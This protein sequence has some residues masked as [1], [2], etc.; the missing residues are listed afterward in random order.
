METDLC[1][2]FVSKCLTISHLSHGN[3]V[4]VFKYFRETI[5]ISDDRIGLNLAVKHFVEHIFRQADDFVVV[6]LHFLL[7]NKNITS[8][9]IILL[10]KQYI[11][12]E[13][14]F[15]PYNE[16]VSLYFA[17]ESIGTAFQWHSANEIRCRRMIHRHVILNSPET[18]R[19]F[20]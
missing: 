1:L 9:A 6:H 5:F 3:R 10:V 13:Q 4:C 15:R 7:E 2:K 12:N 20:N 14:F 11:C 16:C 19:V 8:N 17:V 18:I